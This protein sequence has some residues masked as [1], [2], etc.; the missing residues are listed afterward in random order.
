MA[1]WPGNTIAFGPVAPIAIFDAGPL[2]IS[3]MNFDAGHRSVDL[4]ISRRMA[5]V[6]QSGV[7][8]YGGV[9][10][11]G[12]GFVLTPHGGLR[13]IPPHS[14]LIRVL[15]QLSQ[16]EALRE[17]TVVGGARYAREMERAIDAELASL[18]DTVGGLRPQADVAPSQALLGE[19]NRVRRSGVLEGNALDEH[20]ARLREIAKQL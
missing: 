19:V 5:T 18:R 12:G 8:P 11:G 20:L 17:L 13:R 15:E 4:R 14:P 7:T 6:P 2:R 3:V 9:T 16:L 10:V 1:A